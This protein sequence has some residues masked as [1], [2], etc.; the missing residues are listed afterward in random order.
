MKSELCEAL[1]KSVNVS[2][3][4][5]RQR[6]KVFGLSV[7]SHGLSHLS[8][9]C[10]NCYQL[11]YFFQISNSPSSSSL[12]LLFPRP[13]CIPF[14]PLMAAESASALRRWASPSSLCFS[15]LLVLI[16]F[17]CAG[18]LALRSMILPSHSF[19]S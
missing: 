6:F 14:W 5:Q 10:I 3:A 8:L 11:T 13:S 15:D 18:I 1:P 12:L 2:L 4:F 16:V 19:I 17:C 9:S 7:S